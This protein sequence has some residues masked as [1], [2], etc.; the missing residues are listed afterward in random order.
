MAH[1]ITRFHVGQ[2]VDEEAA[3][4]HSIWKVI[5]DWDCGQFPKDVSRRRIHQ[6]LEHEYADVLCNAYMKKFTGKGNVSS[7]SFAIGFLLDCDCNRVQAEAIGKW[8]PI[9]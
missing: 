9:Y 4:T 3:G 5:Q 2:H 7:V 8:M 6:G 1:L